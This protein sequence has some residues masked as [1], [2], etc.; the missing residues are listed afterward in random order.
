MCQFVDDSDFVAAPGLRPDD[1]LLER[2]VE[3]N[4]IPCSCA[5]EVYQASTHSVDAFE[6]TNLQRTLKLLKHSDSGSNVCLC[7]STDLLHNWTDYVGLVNGTSGRKSKVIAHGELHAL[8]TMENAKYRIT[9]ER[10]YVMLSNRHH[11]LGLDPFKKSGCTKVIHSIHEHVDFYLD[12]GKKVN[13]TNH[14]NK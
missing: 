10:C 6:P 7:T 13:F 12:N 8:F 14:S 1:W 3:N 5:L 4:L 9:I 2:I 11:T